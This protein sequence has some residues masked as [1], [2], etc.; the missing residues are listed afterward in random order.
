MWNYK[1]CDTV[2]QYRIIMNDLKM[3]WNF[4]QD[5]KAISRLHGMLEL[6][7]KEY[8]EKDRGHT[9]SDKFIYK[10]HEK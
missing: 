3:T 9:A 7:E 10:R 2:D 6:L 4:Y 8:M 1:L 5:V